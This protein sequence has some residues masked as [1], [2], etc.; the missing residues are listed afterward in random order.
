MPNLQEHMLRVTAI[1]KIICDNFVKPIDKDLIT[2]ALLLHDLGNMTKIKLERFPEFVQPEG[3][4]YWKKV[5]KEFRKKYGKND[6]EATYK[7]L[8]ELKIQKRI[9]D[10]VHSNE[11][12]KMTKI[13]KSKSFESQIC[14][15]ADARVTPHG[16]ASLDE[17][18]SEV[19]TLWLKYKGASPETFEKLTERAKVVEQQIFD[20]CKIKPEDITEEKVRPLITGL[21]NFEVKTG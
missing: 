4:D 19:R 10:L 21:R 6:Y 20:H 15:Y 16:V 8:S 2:S 1:A 7:I 14:I 9:Y 18:L 13:S 5:L 11:F 12:G 3:F 17:R